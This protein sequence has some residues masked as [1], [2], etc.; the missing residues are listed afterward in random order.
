M[1][2]FFLVSENAPFSVAL[3]LMFSITLLEVITTLIGVG[4]SQIL[5]GLMPDIDTPDFDVDVDVDVDV[6]IDADMDAEMEISTPSVF[7]RFLGWIQ[8]KGVP[9]ILWLLGD[10]VKPV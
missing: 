1:L 3:G 2:D 8:V 10:L 4:F 6:D 9:M 5:E 7:I